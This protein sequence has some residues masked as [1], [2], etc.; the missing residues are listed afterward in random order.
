MYHD[1]LSVLV[2]PNSNRPK[3]DHL[4]NGLWIKSI[5]LDFHIFLKKFYILLENQL[6]ASAPLSISSK[7]QL[8]RFFFV[9]SFELIEIKINSS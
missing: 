5:L 6:S 1:N 4:L 9:F 3:I 7:I 2:H 8:N